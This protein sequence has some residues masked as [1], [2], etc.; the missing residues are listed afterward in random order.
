MNG[1]PF[2]DTNI[3]VYAFALDDSRSEKAEALLAAGGIISVQVLN[4]FVN[5]S[6]QKSR[7]SWEEIEAALSVLKELLGPPQPITF[8]VHE[9]ALRIAR[10]YGYHFYDCLIIASALRA[11]C[12][13]LYSEDLRHGHTIDG[14]TIHNPFS[15]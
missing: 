6:R 8:E 11:N 9:A 12:S 7:R 2:L 14:L 15:D 4:E 5:V 1:K 3:I 10:D 13:L